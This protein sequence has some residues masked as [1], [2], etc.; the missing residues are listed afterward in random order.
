[1]GV[2]NGNNGANLSYYFSDKEKKKLLVKWKVNLRKK[3]Y[4]SLYLR[5]LCGLV[6]YNNY[7][8]G[9]LIFMGS[10][11][12]CLVIT[13]IVFRAGFVFLCQRCNKILENIQFWILMMCFWIISQVDADIW[14]IFNLSNFVFT[15]TRCWHVWSERPQQLPIKCDGLVPQE[16]LGRTRRG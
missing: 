12:N 10:H 15:F 4:L 3:L 1:M 5:W 11:N 9:R 2:N 14:R 13:V 6:L 16:E 7:N 8:M